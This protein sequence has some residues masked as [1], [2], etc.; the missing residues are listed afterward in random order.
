MPEVKATRVGEGEGKGRKRS[1]GVP[2]SSTS[3]SSSTTISSAAPSNSNPPPPPAKN[4]EL[5]DFVIGKAL[6]KGKFGNV[7]LAKEKKSKLNVALKVL[8]KNQ[9]VSGSAPL[10]LRR[11]VEIQSRLDHVCILRLFGYFHN[12]VRNGKERIGTQKGRER[13]Q[14]RTPGTVFLTLFP[15]PLRPTHPFPPSLPVP[16]LPDPGGGNRR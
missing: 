4:W 12:Q 9:M 3:S 6:G 15:P 10:L 7:Y 1:S 8:F 16:R 5:S 2:S 11:E 14:T 13:E